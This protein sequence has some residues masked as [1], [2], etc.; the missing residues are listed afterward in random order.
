MGT[1]N[2][3]LDIWWNSKNH[4]FEPWLTIVLFKHVYI[5]LTVSMISM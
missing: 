2:G 5:Q 1:Y 4:M 3:G